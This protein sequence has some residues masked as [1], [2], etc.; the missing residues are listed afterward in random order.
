MSPDDP[1]SQIALNIRTERVTA[2]DANRVGR[3]RIAIG[4]S[5]PLDKLGEVVQKSEFN[6]IFYAFPVP[7]I[8]LG[9][10]GGEPARYDRDGHE[11]PPR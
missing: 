6:G 1:G 7:R 5:G 4:A 3:L 2:H 10:L 11:T 8:G 9:R